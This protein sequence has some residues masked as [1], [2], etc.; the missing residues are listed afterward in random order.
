MAV[1][2]IELVFRSFVQ[3]TV[4]VDRHGSRRDLPGF[5]A[6]AA[7]IHRQRPAHGSRNAGHEFGAGQVMQCGETRHFRTRHACLRVERAVAQLRREL[8]L[9]GEDHG[10][11]ESTVA[12]EQVGSQPDE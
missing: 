7:R 3:L 8:R 2:D 11:A 12:H 1:G 5:T 6:I 10:A 9:V 4:P